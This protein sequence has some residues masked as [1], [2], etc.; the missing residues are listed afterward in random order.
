MQTYEIRCS[1]DCPFDDCVIIT[2][3]P[4]FSY[5]SDQGGDK[6]G[7]EGDSNDNSSNASNGGSSSGDSGD[8]DGSSSAGKG[9]QGQGKSQSGGSGAMGDVPR[10]DERGGGKRQQTSGQR[11]KTPERD[12]RPADD[13]G[14]SDTG[15][16]SPAKG[17][18]S[19]DGRG[20]DEGSETSSGEAETKG[21]AGS[22]SSAPVGSEPRRNPH[23][24]IKPYEPAPQ[25]KYEPVFDYGIDVHAKQG[26]YGASHRID[27]IPQMQSSIFKEKVQ[28]DRVFEARLKNIM[29]DNAYDRR[30]RGRRRGKLDMKSLY[31]VPA[32]CENVFTLKEARKNKHYNILLLVDES[33]SM[34]GQKADLAAECAV[35]L[36]KS[37]EGINV[38]VAIIGF[39]QFITTRKTWDSAPDYDKI[40]EAIASMNYA[41][42]SGDNCDWDALNKGY[43]MF[44]SAPSAPSGKNILIMLSDG[45]PVSTN[46]RF[47][48]IHGN[49]E[50]APK[51]TDRLD[52]YEKDRTNHLH[53]LVRENAR[54]VTSIGIGIQ[55][56][57]QQIPN[58]TVVHD[59]NK[60]KPTLIKELANQI[61]RG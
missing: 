54:T 17:D 48:D 2:T 52:E 39:N 5:P 28:R 29:I 11:P 18:S 27:A 33:G 23:A 30:V 53:A 37:F 12:S 56:G 24:P 44:S 60:L 26:G 40:Y 41:H 42:G 58:H 19:G 45:Y 46:P 4:P 59:L 49:P 50:N 51:G 13:A 10:S 8:G 36:A 61:K 25:P 55:E 9:G 32:K 16:P 3:I 38:N 6:E 34:K 47:V 21:S 35:F 15:N 57:G 20:S 1:P 22:D 31:K 14:Q 43:Q 7:E